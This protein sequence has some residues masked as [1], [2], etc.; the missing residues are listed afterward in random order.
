MS[1]KDRVFPGWEAAARLAQNVAAKEDPEH[2]RG[3]VG[4]ARTCTPNIPAKP[5]A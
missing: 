1:L 2:P 3:A 5:A 4:S